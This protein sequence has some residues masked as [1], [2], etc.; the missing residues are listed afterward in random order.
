VLLLSGN[1]DCYQP[2]ER[3]WK[4]TRAML[5]VCLRY[6]QPVAII[7]RSSLIARDAQLLAQLNELSAVRVTFSL[8]ILD[9]TLCRALEPHAPPPG[10]RLEAMRV[11]ADAGVPVGVNIAPCIPGITDR[12]LPA[13][14]K[15]THDAGARWANL[16]PLWLP[17]GTA[18][19]FVRR[20]KQALP[21][22][23]E[24]ILRRQLEQR[25]GRVTEDARQRRIDAVGAHWPMTR[26]LFEVHAEKLGFEAPPPWPEPS[27]FQRPNTQ[28]RLF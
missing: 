14:L 25:G 16:I 10:R 13:I 15:A 17:A 18:E 8:P 23:A 12:Q 24:A 19:V 6:R 11:L 28:L 21:L 22:Q 1:T 9:R 2:L 20:L 4:L 3:Q 5:E 7:T 26:R 27:A